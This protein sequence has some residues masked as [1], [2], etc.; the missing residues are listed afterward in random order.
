M[1]SALPFTFVVRK[2]NTGTQLWYFRH[3]SLAKS[4]RIPGLPGEPAFHR[5]HA[6]LLAEAVEEKTAA[7]QRKDETSIRWLTEQYQAS[8]E[9]SRL[10]PSTKTSYKREIGRLNALVGDLPFAKLTK[11][12]SAKC[13]RK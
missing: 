5:E 1:P 9:W 7:D 2:K 4:V 10:K 11:R 3:S 6:R 12:T 8:D 13:E